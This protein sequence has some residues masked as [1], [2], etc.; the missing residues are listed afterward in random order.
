MASLRLSFDDL[1]PPSPPADVGSSSS[2]SSSEAARPRNDAAATPSSNGGG[3]AAAG[4]TSISGGS[5]RSGGRSLLFAAVAAETGAALGRSSGSVGGSSSLNVSHVAPRDALPE[6]VGRLAAAN[7]TLMSSLKQAHADLAA[8]LIDRDELAEDLRG[9]EDAAT[10]AVDAAAAWL[11]A[12]AAWVRQ[13]TATLREELADTRAMRGALHR[14][15]AALRDTA[16]LVP[17]AV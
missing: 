15:L 1:A 8:L 9:A 4:D 3:S 6:Q 14:R 13:R 5:V 12:D 11:T 10:A 7:A 16:S 2:S 17:A